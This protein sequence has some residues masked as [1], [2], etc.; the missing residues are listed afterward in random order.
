MKILYRQTSQK[1][2]IKRVAG[3]FEEFGIRNCYF[4]QIEQKVP[5]KSTTKKRH[6]HTGYEIHMLVA[7]SHI[8]ECE[9]EKIVLNPGGFIMFPAGMTHRLVSSVHPIAKFV[10]TFSLDTSA[11]N[12]WAFGCSERCVHGKIPDCV[13]SAI[14]FIG[15]ENENSF[16][17]SDVLIE[18]RVFE[19]ATLLI[20]ECGGADKT[21]KDCEDAPI[22]ERVELAKQFIRD[23]IE[24]PL[25]V[26]EV[27]SYCYL[28]EK[29]LTRI[30]Q[31][32]EEMTIASYIRIEK[33]KHIESLLANGE[34]S[35]SDICE[36]MK[37]P[38]ES[39][40]NAFFKRYN[41]MPP[42]EFRKMITNGKG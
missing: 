37:F 10:I 7:G 23:N 36:R 5:D 4:K 33:I 6:S 8:Y 25:Q 18:N 38:T 27:A 15:N 11:L 20:R 24:E 31:K 16:I 2:D 29:Q 34:L 22:D 42:G 30:F 19:I 32:F 39:G 17:C 14:E 3:C 1:G 26:G 9:N 40:F 41:G 28:S 35:I 13:L 21:K 12:G